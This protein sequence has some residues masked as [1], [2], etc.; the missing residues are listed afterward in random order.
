MT[1]VIIF[2]MDDTLVNGR[3]KVPRQTYH[4]LNRFKKRG[5]LIGIIS[6]NAMLPFVVGA[7]KLNK[8]TKYLCYKSNADRCVL[9]QNCLSQIMQENPSDTYTLYYADDRLDNI[10]N[11]KE[12]YP[13]VTTYH[14]T[15]VNTLYQFKRLLD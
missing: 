11:V 4:M 12:K 7:K 8:Y 3:M 13:N 5:Y 14:C 2:D 1:V 10:E 9:F 6:Y 15:N